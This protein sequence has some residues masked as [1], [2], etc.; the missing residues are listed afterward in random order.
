MTA[1]IRSQQ[2][3]DGEAGAGT[4]TVLQTERLVLSRLS[5]D[6]CEFI[7]ELVNEP[8][9][10]RFIGDKKVSTP[11]DARRYLR[12]GPIGSY[13][14]FGYGLFLVCPKD[15][16]S[17]AGICGLVKRQ[18]F[19]DPDIGFAFLQRY[20]GTGYALESAKAILDYGFAEL[21]LKRIIAM[22]DPDNEASIRLLARLELEFE[23]M[24]RLPGDEHDINLYAIETI[25][26]AADA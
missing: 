3:G 20:R 26:A 10:K 13:E 2:L 15:S 8:S 25:S 19:D 12:D 23:C 1:G 4:M 16:G 7:V 17:P 6:D 14:R 11:V 22:A 9:F 24:V 5:F 21:G 18:E